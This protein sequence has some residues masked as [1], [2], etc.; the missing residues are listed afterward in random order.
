MRIGERGGRARKENEE[1]KR[2]RGGEDK[3]HVQLYTEKNPND[4]VV[5]SFGEVLEFQ[6]FQAENSHLIKEH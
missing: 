4:L 2:R 6:T 1:R 3:R 5:L